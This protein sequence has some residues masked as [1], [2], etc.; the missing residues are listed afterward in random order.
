MAN[1]KGS[2]SAHLE[3]QSQWSKFC[4]SISGLKHKALTSSSILSLSFQP[5]SPDAIPPETTVGPF[6]TKPK[7]APLCI[8]AQGTMDIK[9]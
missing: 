3:S 1:Q 2:S 9:M 8:I 6:Y 7:V 5:V 4:L